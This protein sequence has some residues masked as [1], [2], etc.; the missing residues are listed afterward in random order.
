MTS[1]HIHAA[2]ARR[3]GTWRRSRLLPALALLGAGLLG[4]SLPALGEDILGVLARSHQTRLTA[5]Q[6]VRAADGRAAILQR[7]FDRLLARQPQPVQAKVELLVVDGPVLAETLAGH[8]VVVHAGLA[9]ANEGERLFML[10]HELGH[11]LLNHWAELGAVYVKHIPGEVNKEATDA[12]A[13]RLG[14][15]ASQLVHGHEYAADAFAWR[16]IRDLGHGL[17]S[18]AAVFHH[19]PNMGDTPTHPASRKRLAALRMIGDD[20]VRSAALP[21]D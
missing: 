19:M 1:Q 15:E 2:S 11:V 14:R 9:D 4:A 17:D 10:A 8:V 18:A 21:Q 12:V 7:D 3:P 16:T 13:G 6:Q 5:L 20:S